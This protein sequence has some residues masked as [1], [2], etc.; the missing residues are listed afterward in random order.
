MHAR[1]SVWAFELT[2]RAAEILERLKGVTAIKFIPGPLPE[3]SN[4]EAETRATAPAVASPEQRRHAE[5]LA[6]EIA[7]EDLRRIVA[8]TIEKALARAPNDRSF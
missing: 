4:E 8:K 1:D 7:S 2:Q 6:S 5:E 3:V